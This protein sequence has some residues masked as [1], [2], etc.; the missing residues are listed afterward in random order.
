M[1]YREGE[2]ILAHTGVHEGMLIATAIIG[3]FMGIG[4]VIGGWRGRQYWLAIWGGGLAVASV[5]YLGWE[6]FVVT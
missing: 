1:R 6:I 2:E 5:V 3:L 4:F